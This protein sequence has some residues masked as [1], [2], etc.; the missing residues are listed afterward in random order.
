MAEELVTC[1]R[2]RGYKAAMN[3][4]VSRGSLSLLSLGALAG[5]SGPVR[6]LSAPPASDTRAT[7]AGPLCDGTRCRCEADASKAGTAPKGFKRFKVELGPTDHELWGHVADNHFYKSRERANECY[8]IDLPPGE[9]PIG[10]RARGEG[11]F[12]ARLQISEVGG[13]PVGFYDTFDFQCGAPGICDYDGLD[14]FKAMA[15]EVDS[16]KF[17]PCGSVR[18]L[19]VDWLTGRAPDRLHPEDFQLE[20]TM[21]V[22]NFAPKH[23]AGSDECSR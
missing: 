8:Y 3:S 13:K 7:L 11:G 6:E 1:S 10:L 4:M 9:H 16:G 15:R 18:V 2:L 20:A 5:C 23:A 12:G 21:K 22:Y 14:R 19:G 17:D